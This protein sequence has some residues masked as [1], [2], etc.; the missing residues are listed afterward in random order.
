M[1]AVLG[2]AIFSSG[3]DGVLDASSRVEGKHGVLRLS[4]SVA[5]T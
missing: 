5:K 4:V 1:V 3:G 2:F